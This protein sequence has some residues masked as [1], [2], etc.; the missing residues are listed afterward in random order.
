MQID[1]ALYAEMVSHALEDT[2]NECCGMVGSESGVAKRVYRATNIHASPLRYEIEAGEM[3]SLLS[4][5]EEAGWELGR[6][7][8]RTRAARPIRRRPTST[9]RS[10]RSSASRSGRGRST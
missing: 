7:T 4:E 6:F 3:F 9:S 10:H 1:R 8:I 2:P 5:I